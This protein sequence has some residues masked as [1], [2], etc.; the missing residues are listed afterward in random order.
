MGRAV[1]VVFNSYYHINPVQ[2]PGSLC[3][4]LS[5]GELSPKY[6]PLLE[7]IARWISKSNS[8]AVYNM[9]TAR[10]IYKMTLQLC[11]IWP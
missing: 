11:I 2:T 1:R 6:D 8:I 3:I 7:Y 10:E 5:L 9:A 4:E